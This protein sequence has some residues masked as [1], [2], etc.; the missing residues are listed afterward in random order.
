MKFWLLYLLF[1]ESYRTKL[2]DGRRL[3]GSESPLE[4]FE[5][6]KKKKKKF[7]KTQTKIEIWQKIKSSHYMVGIF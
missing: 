3:N 6:G 4:I 1:E 2:N 5:S 7:K